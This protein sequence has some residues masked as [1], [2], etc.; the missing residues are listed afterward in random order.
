MHPKIFWPVSPGPVSRLRSFRESQAIFQIQVFNIIWRISIINRFIHERQGY[1]RSM[2]F[3]QIL[4]NIDQFKRRNESSRSVSEKVNR[5]IG[6]KISAAFSLK[7]RT[8]IGATKTAQKIIYLGDG[9]EK[10]YSINYESQCF[11]IEKICETRRKNHVHFWNREYDT[12]FLTESSLSAYFSREIVHHLH[13][14]RWHTFLDLEA[15][16]CAWIPVEC[17]K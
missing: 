15:I 4:V 5:W 9:Y 14:F 10:S 11:L 13:D 1:L 16:V 2:W 3:S 6:G 7:A 17:L 12:S 8:Y